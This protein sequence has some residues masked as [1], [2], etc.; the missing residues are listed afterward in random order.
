M[1]M[2]TTT[3]SAFHIFQCVRESSFWLIIVINSPSWVLTQ[4]NVI[5]KR[6]TVI[7]MWVHASC[8]SIVALGH[9]GD[10]HGRSRRQSLKNVGVRGNSR[11]NSRGQPT[12]IM[13]TTPAIPRMLRMRNTN[14]IAHIVWA[15][16][17]G[18]PVSV[19]SHVTTGPQ[20]MIRFLKN[21][22]TPL[23]WVGT[24]GIS[25]RRRSNTVV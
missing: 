24:A 18:I 4:R 5:S 6:R 17:P 14:P 3:A 22:C 1:K 13:T 9:D 8:N 25:F 21:D 11:Y 12:F 10:V 16:K 15:T 7:V 20:H 23:T 19:A 2:Q